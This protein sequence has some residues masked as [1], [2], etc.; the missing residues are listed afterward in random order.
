M[1]VR[2]PRRLKQVIVAAIV[3]TLRRGHEA[4]TAENGTAK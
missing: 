2:K 1:M 4:S 3:V